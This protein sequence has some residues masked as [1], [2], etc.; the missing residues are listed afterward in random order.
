MG[1]LTD[2]SGTNREQERTVSGQSGQ[3]RLA[4]GL[5]PWG[6]GPEPGATGPGP[7]TGPEIGPRGLPASGA[8]PGR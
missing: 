7:G 1:L 4:A 3:G 5:S 6:P 2:E 8:T